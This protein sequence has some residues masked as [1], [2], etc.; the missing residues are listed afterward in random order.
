[1][2]DM[3]TIERADSPSASLGAREPMM[4][5][6]SHVACLTGHNGLQHESEEYHSGYAR[7]PVSVV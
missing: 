7:T 6:D 3:S 4:A 1:M 2:E 5:Q